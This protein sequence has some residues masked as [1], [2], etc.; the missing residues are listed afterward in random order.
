MLYSIGMYYSQV[1]VSEVL[2]N[3]WLT[4]DCSVQVRHREIGTAKI[5]LIRRTRSRTNDFL[6]RWMSWGMKKWMKG[7]KK[8]SIN[9]RKNDLQRKTAVMN[10]CLFGWRSLNNND[11]NNLI[12][13]NSPKIDSFAYIFSCVSQGGREMFSIKI[14][15]TSPKGTT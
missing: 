2:R 7:K 12:W 13:E 14:I 15:K 5:N 6:S 3:F 1:R 10:E 4:T 9:E 8:E 11:F